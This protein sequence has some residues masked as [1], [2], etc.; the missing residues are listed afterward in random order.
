MNENE[1]KRLEELGIDP[2]K[3]IDLS[4][5]ITSESDSS[6]DISK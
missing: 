3:V 1:L 6:I 2:N 5:N 4:I